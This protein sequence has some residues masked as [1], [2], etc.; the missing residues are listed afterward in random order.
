VYAVK[1]LTSDKSDRAATLTLHNTYEHAKKVFWIDGDGAEEEYAVVQPGAEWSV[2]TFVGH[3]WRTRDENNLAEELTF[4][5]DEAKTEL[6][7]SPED[8]KS[9]DSKAART[10]SVSNNTGVAIQKVWLDQEGE[11]Q[12]YGLLEP[13]ATETIGSF[14][15]HVW[16]F[17]DSTHPNGATLLTI[18]VE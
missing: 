18:T 7:L 15:G 11:E 13:G 17:K 14:V 4:S 9:G 12:D 16:R 6:D 5:I 10:V 2:D 3:Y 8:L 1:V